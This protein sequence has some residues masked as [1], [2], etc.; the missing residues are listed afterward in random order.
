MRTFRPFSQRVFSSAS[1]PSIAAPIAAR[2]LSSSAIRPNAASNNTR[3]PPPAPEAETAALR[4][5]KPPTSLGTTKRLPEFNLVDKVVLI[6]GAA[7]GLGLVQAEALLE[8]GAIVLLSRGSLLG[9][10]TIET[11]TLGSSKRRKP[12]NCS[13]SNQN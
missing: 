3:D 2:F 13:N 10:F 9:G 4:G 8:A 5:G 11:T 6:S 7:R 12:Q 1:K